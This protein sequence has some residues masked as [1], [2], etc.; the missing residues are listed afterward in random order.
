[1]SV[2][3]IKVLKEMPEMVIPG[4]SGTLVEV[5]EHRNVNGTKGPTT[6][7]D[8]KL[9]D[10]N[11][12][13]LGTAWGMPDISPWLNKRVIFVSNKTGN[14]KL[15][16]VSIKERPSKDGSK[17]YKNLYVTAAGTMHDPDTYEA[18]R[19]APPIPGMQAQP[20]VQRIPLPS[21]Q[22]AAQ[23]VPK[24]PVQ[25]PP[26]MQPHANNP[27]P[28]ANPPVQGITCG[29]AINN[30]VQLLIATESFNKGGFDD[31][32]IGRSVH[33]IASMI[34]RVSQMLEKG[35]L[36]NPDNPLD[37]VVNQVMNS[38]LSG[39]ANVPPPARPKPTPGPA[40]SA[41]PV[42]QENEDDDY[43]F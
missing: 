12:W 36:W 24:P 3:T 34:I 18:S 17:M 30:A 10:G 19:G 16:G 33:R 41:F 27:A 35:D 40:G 31:E 29:M 20:A 8:L 1:M 42:Y 32:M 22:G 13:I 39:S 21:D 11:D 2:L 28:R 43:P 4:T 25:L 9:Q 6:A 5:K 26:Q 38:P 15:A 37:S 7:Q 14:N 23:F